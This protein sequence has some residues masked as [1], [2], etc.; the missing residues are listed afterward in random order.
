MML[1]QDLQW[2]SEARLD[3]WPFALDHAVYLWN[4]MPQRESRLAPIEIF[5]STR[6]ADYRHLQHAHVWGCPT[7]VLDPML[8]D[9]KKI[10]KWQPAP[11]AAFTLVCR[12][13]T[14]P[15]LGAS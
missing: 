7:Y 14:L 2:P 1:H 13:N 15:M 5:G 11:G 6:F 9:G 3:L 8:Q 4:H 12:Y 10:P